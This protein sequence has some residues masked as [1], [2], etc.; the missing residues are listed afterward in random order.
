M[1]LAHVPLYDE[2]LQPNLYAA[3]AICLAAA[4]TA[5]LLRLYARQLK[6]QRLGWDD[7]M[8]IVALFFTTVFVAMCVFVAAYGMGRHTVVTALQHPERVVPF[9]KATLAAGVLYNPVLVCT[10]VSILRPVFNLLIHGDPE[11]STRDKGSYDGPSGKGLHDRH[12]VTIGGHSIP[13]K[14]YAVVARDEWFEHGGCVT[15]S[16]ATGWQL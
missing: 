12:L 11:G 7:Y 3:D 6:G 9:A 16:V 10:K 4:F 13:M 1:T 15:G 2:N 8:I 5:V 14:R